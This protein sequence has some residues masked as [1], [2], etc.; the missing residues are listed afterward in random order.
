MTLHSM[1]MYSLIE[2]FRQLPNE[3]KL[4]A[5]VDKSWKDIMRRTEDRPNALRAA[6]APGVLEIL[7]TNNSNLEKIHKCLEVSIAAT[8]ISHMLSQ[9]QTLQLPKDTHVFL[10][11]NSIAATTISHSQTY[12]F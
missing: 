1:T 10:K 4:F 11:I 9:I 8:A 3:A 12:Y 7:Q 6:V 5:S 2:Y